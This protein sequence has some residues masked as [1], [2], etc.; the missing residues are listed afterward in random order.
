MTPENR[1]GTCTWCG[2]EES[3]LRF[4]VWYFDDRVFTD[5]LCDRCRRIFRTATVNENED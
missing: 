3:E 4:V 2:R 5:W 1:E